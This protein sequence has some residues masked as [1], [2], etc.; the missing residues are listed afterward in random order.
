MIDYDRDDAGT[1]S[2]WLA[3]LTPHPFVLAFVVCVLVVDTCRNR[4]DIIELQERV[5]AVEEGRP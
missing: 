1:W 4:I 2:E 5:D 3:D